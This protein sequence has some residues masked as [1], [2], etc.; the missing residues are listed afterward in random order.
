MSIATFEAR[1]SRAIKR[2]KVYDNDIPAYAKDAVKTLEKGHNWKHMWTEEDVALATGVNYREIDLLKSCQWIKL[3]TDDGV[4]HP[5]KKVSPI[6]LWALEEGSPGG[7][8]MSDL[9]TVQFDRTPNS[10]LTLRYG[11]YLYSEYDDDLPWL[12]LDEGLLMAQTMLEMAPLLKNPAFVSMYSPIVAAKLELLVTAEV[13]AEYGGQDQRMQPYA[14]EM[15]EWVASGV[16]D[17]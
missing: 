4:Y 6:Q 14:D 15:E 17:A 12:N 13:E 8:W 10:D 2:G 9:T 7:Y 1:V 5:V 3:K 16:T 11:Y